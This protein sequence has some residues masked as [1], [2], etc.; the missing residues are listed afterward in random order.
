MGIDIYLEWDN[1]TE[2]EKKD[3]CTEKGVLLIC[4]RKINE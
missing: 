2:K 4:S 3:Q 1:Q